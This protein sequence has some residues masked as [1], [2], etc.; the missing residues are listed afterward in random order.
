MGTHQCTCSVVLESVTVF[1][2]FNGN[3]ANSSSLSLCRST[4]PLSV[5]HRCDCPIIF[6]HL[7]LNPVFSQSCASFFFFR[8]VCPRPLLYSPCVNEPLLRCWAMFCA[9]ALWMCLP[10]RRARAVS[11]TIGRAFDS[12]S[13]PSLFWNSQLLL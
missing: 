5:S 4:P 13:R 3:S 9:S 7:Y 1:S 8:Q 6:I 11:T 2:T 10:C 12:A